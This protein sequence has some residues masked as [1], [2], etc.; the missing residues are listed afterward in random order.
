MEFDLKSETENSSKL[1]K[2]DRNFIKNPRPRFKTWKFGDYADIFH[3]IKYSATRHA[4]EPSLESLRY[5]Y[6]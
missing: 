3:G 4:A 2:R 1:P 6:K 5:T